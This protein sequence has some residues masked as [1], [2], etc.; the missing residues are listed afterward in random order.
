MTSLVPKQRCIVAIAALFCALISFSLNVEKL[1][2]PSH[3]EQAKA[4]EEMFIG[5]AYGGSSGVSGGSSNPVRTV[6]TEAAKMEQQIQQAKGR[7][8]KETENYRK[9]LVAKATDNKDTI[10]RGNKTAAASAGDGTASSP[11][12]SLSSAYRNPV[13]D[14]LSQQQ[15]ENLPIPVRIMEQYKQWH[16]VDVLRSETL[17]QLN[18]RKYAVGFYVCPLSAGTSRKKDRNLTD[19]SVRP[20]SRLLIADDRQ[21]PF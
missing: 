20:R 5:Y 1:I 4:L 14:N 13:P 16:G 3:A 11:G 12:N 9:T 15:K 7:L 21:R 17:N 2:I 10:S 8:A 18:K 6:H 19:H